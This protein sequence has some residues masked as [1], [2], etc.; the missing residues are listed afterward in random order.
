MVRAIVGN[1][2]SHG[3]IHLLRDLLQG[4]TCLEV[5]PPSSNALPHTLG[6]TRTNSWRE[7][8]KH[9]ALSAPDETGAELIAQEGKLLGQ[10]VGS[11][12]LHVAAHNLGSLCILSLVR[13]SWKSHILFPVCNSCFI[14]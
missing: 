11:L 1:P 12:A 2:T 9:L 6:R 13:K 3:W 4:S 7:P 14:V 5:Q 8:H 10:F